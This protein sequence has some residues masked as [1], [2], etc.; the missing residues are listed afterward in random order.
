MSKMNRSRNSFNSNWQSIDIDNLETRNTLPI[1]V[2][3]IAI[4]VKPGYD[5]TLFLD[6]IKKLKSLY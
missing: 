3:D 4:E 5:Q 6:V 1:I 2:G